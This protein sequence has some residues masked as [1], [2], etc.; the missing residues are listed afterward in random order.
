MV[1]ALAGELPQPRL[2]WPAEVAGEVTAAA[3]ELT[4]IPAGTPVCA[5]TIDAWAESIAAGVTE[6]GDLMIMYGSTVFLVQ[7]MALSR[8]VGVALDDGR[9][10]PGTSRSPPAWRPEASR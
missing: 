3:A 6:P 7:C 2:L 8:L 1:A 10:D 9:R 4:G 5:G